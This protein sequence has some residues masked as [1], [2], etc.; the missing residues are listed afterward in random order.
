[1]PEM[2][3]L[4]HAKAKANE[5]GILMGS[6]LK[7]NSDLSK[8]GVSMAHAKGV[9]L[10]KASFRPDRVYY[11]ELA[12]AKQ[13]AEIILQE[14]GIAIDITPLAALNERDFGKYDGKPY[15]FVL[16]AFDKYP[17]D[18]PTVEPVNKFIARVLDGFNRIKSAAS[19][20]TLVV[21]H[22]N[23]VMVMQTAAFNPDMLERFWELGDPEYCEG[24]TYQY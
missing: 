23:P 12:R 7:M 24:F 18:P 20:T 4:R 11:S 3:V 2:L 9:K 14:L 15:K 19:G 16:E 10:R 17:V 8:A 1:M 13:T 21:T 5:Q 22:S 6:S